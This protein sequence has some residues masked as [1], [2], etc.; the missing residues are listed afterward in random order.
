MTPDDDQVTIGFAVPAHLSVLA[1][2][3]EIHAEIGRGGMGVVY[4]A[5]DRQTGDLV[6]IKV[7]HPSTASDP[8]LVERFK[9]E[10]LLARRIT[11]RNVCRV[12]D[13]NDFAGVTVISMELVAGRS[14]RDLLKGI[15]AFPIRQGLAIARQLIA[16]LGEAHAQGVVHRDL[17]PENIVIGRD[18]A[19]KIM[20]FGIARL[21]DSR[22]TATGQLLGTPAYM[23][24]EQAEG[25]PVDARSD[26]YSL[27]LVLYE[28][29]CGQPAFAADT[30]IALVAKHVSEI[31]AAPR[32]VEADL[33]PWIDA[34]IRR[35]LEKQPAK[36]FQSVVELDAALA[37]RSS[38]DDAREQPAV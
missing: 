12:Y 13:L 10:L 33:P 19:V 37:V 21:M 6:A 5:L 14:L 22:L 38:L 30:P 18:G 31:P 7:L 15:G 1:T 27:G 8:H 4:R 17:K 32:T 26:V 29:F 2:R 11:H 28:M 9:N 35:C 24:P 20:D 36:R 23:N 25:K 16:G 3:Y 34:A